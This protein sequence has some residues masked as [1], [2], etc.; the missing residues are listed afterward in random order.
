MR[1]VTLWHDSCHLLDMK[2]FNLW[3]LFLLVSFPLR[4]EVEIGAVKHIDANFSQTKQ[5]SM[6]KEP[7]VLTGHFAYDAPSS[8]VWQYDKGIE[9][10]LPEQ[11]LSFI[12]SA[13]SGKYLQSNDDFQ[14]L[15]KDGEVTLVPLRRQLRKLFSSVVLHLQPNTFIANQVV[16]YEATGDI[17]TICFTNIKAD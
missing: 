17:T 6:L 10:R 11:M 14:V 9:A 12:A 13:V 5:Q 3:I 7:Q 8:V 1:D 16:L 2:R 15:E 4:A